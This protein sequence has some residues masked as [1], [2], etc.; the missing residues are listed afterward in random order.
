LSTLEGINL[1]K[2]YL[3]NF[4]VNDNTMAYLSGNENEVYTVQQK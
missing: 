4:D 3:M 2:K 1:V